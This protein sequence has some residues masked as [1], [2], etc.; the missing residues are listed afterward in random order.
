[1]TSKLHQRSFGKVLVKAL[2]DILV[3]I[4][5][6]P[7]ILCTL[8]TSLKPIEGSGARE[9]DLLIACCCF[10]VILLV[11]LLN[12]YYKHK[13]PYYYMNELKI[14]KAL[15]LS[16]LIPLLVLTAIVLLPFYLLF[17]TSIKNEHE[18]IR[19]VFT[20]WPEE[21][22]DLGSYQN[23]FELQ[24]RMDLSLVRAFINS[25][26]YAIIPTV[27]GIFTSAA[28]AY[29]YTKLEF[30]GKGAMYGFMIMTMM[31][32]GC[33]TMS[34][35][36]LL[37]EVIGWTHSPLPLIIPG[38]FGGAGT[39]MFLREF[40]MGLPNGLL[41]AAE[42]DGAGRW[43]RFFSII[44]PLAKPALT[45]QFILGFI[46]GFNSYL[47]PLLYLDETS[48][49]TVQIFVN[50]MNGDIQIAAMQATMA[51]ACVCVLVPML[52]LYILFQKTILGGI[53]ISSGLKG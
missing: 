44:L 6:V 18:A 46:S 39:V 27:V 13:D 37:Y 12:G 52:I 29:A 26:V 15:D 47:G 19:F 16:N 42:I 4:L 48:D 9:R 43:R 25:F 33:A 3:P 14:S 45:A 11:K 24:E 41:E 2:N 50:W 1:M 36:Y 31:M 30:R 21:G 10:G 35:G 5:F 40:M 49:Y 28:A 34:T 7:A 17:V 22:I 32:P 8:L 38:L 23:L 53:S 51:A 20:W